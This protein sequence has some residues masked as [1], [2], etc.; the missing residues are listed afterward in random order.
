MWTGDNGR[1]LNLRPEGI[2]VSVQNSLH[3]RLSER[4]VLLVVAAAHTIA[5]RAVASAGKALAVKLQAAG[6]LAVAVLPGRGS[7][8]LCLPPGALL[9]WWPAFSNSSFF[10]AL[11]T[12]G[13]GLQIASPWALSYS[14]VQMF[15]FIPLA[16]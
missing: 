9:G 6:I 8:F 14:L 15:S 11:N 7:H 13:S 3:R 4:L 10:L 12:F 5:L 16:S 2:R 1:Y